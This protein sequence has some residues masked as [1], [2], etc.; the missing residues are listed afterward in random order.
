MSLF[1]TDSVTLAY[2]NVEGA[3]RWWIEAFDCKVAKVPPD[4]D[5]PLPSDI[6]LQLP[7][8]GAPTIL[9]SAKAEVE[10]AGFDRPSPVASVIFLQQ[11]KERARAAHESWSSPRTDP[12]RW[13]YPILRNPRQRGARHRSLQGTLE[14]AS[15]WRL[16]D[17]VLSANGRTTAEAEKT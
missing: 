7:G 5:C 16:I 3:K 8:H 15:G 1:Y 17:R 4:W 13:R 9:L 12:R 6:A 2:S 14:H 10:Q 11:V